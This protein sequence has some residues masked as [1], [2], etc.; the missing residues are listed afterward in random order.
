MKL[1]PAAGPSEGIRRMPQHRKKPQDRPTL[2]FEWVESETF[3][4]KPVVRPAPSPLPASDTAF[5]PK[6][7]VPG[8]EHRIPRS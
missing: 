2:P 3:E 5:L 4:L 1:V 8:R 7:K 6:S